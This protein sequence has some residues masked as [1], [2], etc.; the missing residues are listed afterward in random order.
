VQC[1]PDKIR[2]QFRNLASLFFQ[3]TYIVSNHGDDI[4]IHK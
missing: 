4:L 2:N 1:A 3:S